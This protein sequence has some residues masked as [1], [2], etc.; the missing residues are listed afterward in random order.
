M[1][2]ELKPCPFCGSTVSLEVTICDITIRCR[3]CSTAM[4]VDNSPMYRNKITNA[5]NNRV[6][7]I[8]IDV[9]EPEKESTRANEPLIRKDHETQIKKLT[10]ALTLLTK[11]I[12]EEAR[13]AY[14]LQVAHG[15]LEEFDN[16]K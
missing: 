9:A 7:R 2:D 4:T 8:A 3:S 1:S 5:W 14:A 6:P 15:V 11:A 12:N 10:E 16:G 13:F